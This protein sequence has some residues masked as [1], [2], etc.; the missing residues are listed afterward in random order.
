MLL[1]LERSHEII[2]LGL[3]MFLS[4]LGVMG[5]N[6]REVHLSPFV[7]PLSKTGDA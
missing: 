3:I 1:V 7:N 4:P 5:Y 2:A 6:Q